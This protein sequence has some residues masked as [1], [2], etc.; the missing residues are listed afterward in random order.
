MVLTPRSPSP[1]SCWPTLTFPLHCLRV[2]QV[3]HEHPPR[4]IVRALRPP[5]RCPSR[6]CPAVVVGVGGGTVGG[7]V[8]V[9][10]GGSGGTVWT[11]VHV[12]A[13][14]VLWVGLG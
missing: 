11:E 2:F 14:G 5:L 13:S 6:G 10:V 9:V 1:L 4:V 12:I 8:V 7:G 3:P